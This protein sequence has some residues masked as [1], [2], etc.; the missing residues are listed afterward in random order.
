MAIADAK[1]M[2]ATPE[3]RKQRRYRKTDVRIHD[4]GR[5]HDTL[6]GNACVRVKIDRTP[7]TSV[8]ESAF[9]CT[10]DVAESMLRR[11]FEQAKEG[12]WEYWGD[13]AQDYFPGEHITVHQVG[14]SGGYLLVEGLGD[15]YTSDD[16][17]APTPGTGWSAQTLA[18]WGRFE[19]NVLADVKHLCSAEWHI[20]NIRDG[21][22]VSDYERCATCALW[23]TEG[24]ADEFTSSLSLTRN[25]T[26]NHGEVFTRYFCCDECLEGFDPDT[27]LPQ[28][29][30]YTLRIPGLLP[31]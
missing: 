23:M 22:M 11:S 24:E 30:R 1:A 25:F 8:I 5:W 26:N 10:E 6:S 9:R 19:R 21:A 29:C 13:Y 4:T 31:V 18:R 12:F 16:Y 3:K 2:A 15:P 28:E 17:G 7:S 20:A 14:H 27:M